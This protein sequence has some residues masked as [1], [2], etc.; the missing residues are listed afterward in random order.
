VNDNTS[1]K[2][3]VPV[4]CRLGPDIHAHAR[5]LAIRRGGKVGVVGTRAVLGV[6][7]D[8]V[9][10]KT[11]CA[12]VVYL[13]VSGTLIETENVEKVV[14]R[15]R[16]VEQLGNGGINI[17]GRRSRSGGVGVHKVLGGAGRSIVVEVCS[18]AAWIRLS[19]SVVATAGGVGGGSGRLPPELRGGSVPGVGEGNTGSVGRVVDAPGAIRC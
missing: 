12:V 15:V 18:A 11:S 7:N 19:N 9:V 2:A 14:V 5:K 17:A 8:L 4:R 16:G 10:A 13:K 1:L 3:A 6:Q